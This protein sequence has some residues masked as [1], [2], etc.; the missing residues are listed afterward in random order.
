MRVFQ[1]LAPAMMCIA[2]NAFGNDCASAIQVKQQSRDGKEQFIA[3]NIS[4]R[5]IIAYVVTDD[6][7]DAG[8][9]PVHVFSG[10]FTGDDSLHPGAHIQIQASKL[11][12]L[13]PAEVGRKSR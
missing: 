2:L 3:K 9:N 12:L 7:G 6:T 8:G 13:V 4:K 5:P 1:L 11:Y 10:V